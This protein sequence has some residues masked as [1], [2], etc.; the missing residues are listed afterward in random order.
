MSAGPASA[1]AIELAGIHKVFSAGELEVHALRG[2]DLRI[3]RGEFVAIMGPSGS[4]KTT[5]MEILGCLSRPTAGSYRLS[6]RRV[7]EIP[8]DGLAALRGEEIG[9]VFQS[10]N[11][12]PR[13][14][15]VENTELPLA[16]RGVS[17]PERRRRALEVLERVGLAHRAEHLP[18]RI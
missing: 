3:E 1:P 14:S 16:Y 8:P 13:L 4:G 18:G 10:F 12:L 5:L 6:G 9:F 11:L 2:I 17:R 7:E 15:V